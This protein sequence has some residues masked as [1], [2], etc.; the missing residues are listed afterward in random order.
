MAKKKLNNNASVFR[1]AKLGKKKNL[2]CDLY[3]GDCLEWLKKLPDKSVDLIII[4]PPYIFN[5]GGGGGAFGNRDYYK[6][7]EPLGSGFDFQV[8]SDFERLQEEINLYIFCNKNLLTDLVVYFKTHK[9]DLLTDILIW[10]K[11]NPIPSC[12]NKY[13]SNVEYVLFIHGKGVKIYGDYH[14]KSKVY[15]SPTL[16]KDKQLYKHPT[17]KPVPLLENYIR[18]SSKPGETVLDCFA[19]SSSVGEASL[20]TG[21]HY[22]GIE[23]NPK[24]FKTSK[25]RLKS[26]HAELTKSV[27]KKSNTKSKNK[28]GGSI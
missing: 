16:K 19:G 12:H 3:Q 24:H 6:E 8:F 2:K 20:R 25:Q 7:I 27:A 4:D 5:N 11:T 10:H 26:T 14:S 21:R 23:L 28:K 13:L 15:S 22:I 17:T 9:P 1:R 18:N